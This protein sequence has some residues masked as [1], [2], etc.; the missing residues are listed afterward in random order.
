MV[1]YYQ[2]NKEEYRN[3]I[4]KYPPGHNQN[5]AV[6]EMLLKKLKRL[7]FRNVIEI[8]CGY[9]LMIREVMDAFKPRYC[10]GIDLSEDQINEA[11]RY[12]A[13]YNISLALT[14]IINYTDYVK[15]ELVFCSTVL[16]HIPPQY[17]E[18]AVK[19]VCKIS[20]RH[21]VIVEPTKEVIAKISRVG[22]QWLHDYKKLFSKHKWRIKEKEKVEGYPLLYMRFGRR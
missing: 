17:I 15:Y 7:R 13:G 3:Y 21:I 12:L 1:D 4:K 5:V 22:D 14:D 11:L 9:G 19:N 16:S 8:G 18:E 2:H 6:I 10:V 20:K